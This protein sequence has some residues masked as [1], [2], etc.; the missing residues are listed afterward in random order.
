MK[1]VRITLTA[2]SL[3]LAACTVGPNYRAPKL[4]VPDEF[5]ES[6]EKAGAPELDAWWKSFGDQELEHL[7]GRALASSPDLAVASA[8]LREARAMLGSVEAQSKPR[9]DG[10]GSYTDS[11]FSE[12]GFLQGLGG[13]G[14][15]GAIFPGQEIE[16]EQV[17]LE[18]SWELDFF[19]AARRANEAARAEVA[20]AQ[21]ELRD[22][23]IVLAA[24]VAKRYV[25]L[26]ELQARLA[27]A[28]Q[29]LSDQSDT[30]AVVHEQAAAGV[31]S[32]LDESRATTELASVAARVPDLDGRVAIAIHQLEALLGAR[33]GALNDELQGAADVPHS[34]DLFGA[35]IPSDVLR[36]RPD[37]RAAERRLAAAS[38]RVG[39]ATAD[40]FPR[41]SLTG[42]FGLQSQRLA[43]LPEW[44]SRFWS[45]G[46]TVRW[47]IF[48]FGRVRERVAIE[49]ARTDE[50]FARYQSSVVRALS[51]VEIALV[52]LSRERRRTEQLDRAVVSAQHSVELARELYRN[53]LLEFLALLDSE[54]TLHVA[55]ESSA[56]GKAAVASDTVALFEA[57][58]GGW[59][60]AK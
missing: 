44:D 46:P 47:P 16:L 58:G 7:I 36:R 20:G 28:E 30:L 22:A 18:A 12:N 29:D 49:D 45:V 50:A 51:E 60:A 3:A 17:G 14:P 21:F 8:R 11:R 33:P 10:A 13:G 32:D 53:G 40:Y 41:F 9:I 6:A 4:D 43:D 59:S 24:E 54:R 25:E 27:L 55:E 42:S 35:G 5:R 23:W 39:Q 37:V 1:L 19:G 15:P 57:L 48:D 52:R 31:A 26:R 34:P 38:A 2:V 56:Q